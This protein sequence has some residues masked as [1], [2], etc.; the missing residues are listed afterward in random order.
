[1]NL[2]PQDQHSD[3]DIW[4]ALEHAH[5]KDFLLDSS[6]NLE[7]DCGEGGQN[8]CLTFQST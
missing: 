8:L 4:Q 6:H 5:L 2:D 1:M 3:E 7:F